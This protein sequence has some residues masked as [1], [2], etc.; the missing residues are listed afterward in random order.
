MT[1]P[2]LD[3][4]KMHP[5]QEGRLVIPLTGEVVPGLIFGSAFRLL[6]QQVRGQRWG[7]VELH[8]DAVV[9]DAIEPSSEADLKQYLDDLMESVHKEAEK[10][11]KLADEDIA[12]RDEAKRK[13][14]END[15][16]MTRRF[17]EISG[18]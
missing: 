10:E 6:A 9:V 5:V 8:R 1:D 4:Q 11:R 3:W 12:H 17:R 15:E 13:Q 14:A 2:K 16:E 18:E 7:A